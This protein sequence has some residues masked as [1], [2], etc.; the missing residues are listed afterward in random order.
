MSFL[1]NH[2]Q[3]VLRVSN[4]VKKFPG[5]TALGGV[6]LELYSG[7]IHSLLGENGSGKSTLAKVI[8][9]IYSPDSGAIEVQGKPV[10]F[11][12]PADAIR[13]G[14]FYIPQ[15]PSLIEN[16]TVT[17]NILLVLKSC[18][19]LTKVGRVRET[20]EEEVSKLGYRI[21]PDAEA[22]RLSYTQKQIVELAKAS[23]LGVKILIV[24]E[25]TTYL[26]K[27]VRESFYRYMRHIKDEGKTIVLITHKIG[28]AV[29]VADRVTVLR[30]GMVVRT[31]ERKELNADMIR[32][33][34][35]GERV[36]P[37]RKEYSGNSTSANVGKEKMELVRLDDIWANDDTGNVAL[38]GV[39]LRVGRGEVLGVAGISGNG[40]KEL[41]EVLVG[42]RDVK[43]G[44]YYLDGVE[45]T[46]RGTKAIRAAGVGFIPEAPLHYSFSGDLSLVENVAITSSNN[47][48]IRWSSLAAKVREFVSTYGISVASPKTLVKVLSG[49]NVMRLAV[50]RELELSKKM[51]VA[52]NATRSLD[53]MFS[54]MFLSTIRTLARR[55][56]IT[57]VY[58]SESLDEVLAVSDR[59]A[60]ISSGKIVGLFEREGVERDTVEKLMV[61]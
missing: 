1:P 34:M 37:S 28:E 57:V 2:S 53:E 10:R 31:L 14:I 22:S 5:V 50:A 40:Q 23:I 16:L 60:V 36:F 30:S 35:F 59:I 12:S 52:Y 32:R 18:G 47:F 7:E 56:N 51:L 38:R 17:E 25:V 54:E 45:V 15:A 11:T 13:Y 61:M 39:T 49:G 42:L 58:I 21:D 19:L 55:D 43:R 29:D 41:A 27:V 33:L 8:A 44:H 20:I 46:N 6:S 9:G 4:I 24:D 26:P 3:I 48:F